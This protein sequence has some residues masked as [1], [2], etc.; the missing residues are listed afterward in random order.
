MS[1]AFVGI[2]MKSSGE[3]RAPIDD[4]KLILDQFK[5]NEFITFV[6]RFGAPMCV[7]ATDVESVTL[8]ELGPLSKLD[9]EE[10]EKA[11]V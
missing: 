3:Y 5:A 7:R 1:E 6:N 2:S 4:Y 8:W 9:D 10:K 11:L